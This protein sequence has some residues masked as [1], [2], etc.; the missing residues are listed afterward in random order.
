MDC[1]S[2]KNV[3][4]IGYYLNSFGIGGTEKTAQLFAN[5]IDKSKFTIHLI[6]KNTDLSRVPLL[7]QHVRLSIVQN[8]DEA[9][10]ILADQKFDIIHVFRSGFPEFPNPEI[11]PTSKFVE[12]NVFGFIDPNP[13]VTKTIYMSEW[14]QNYSLRKYNSYYK[15][16]TNRFTF[17]N[18]PTLSPATAD[19]I[20]LSNVDR[21]TI[22]LGRNGR[23]DPGTYSDVSVKAARNLIS[24]G[25][26]I[27]FLAMSPP[28]NMLND[29]SDFD[30]PHTVLPTSIDEIELSKFYNTIDIYCESRA[31]GHTC[32]NVIQEAMMHRKPVITHIATARENF[33]V[34]QAQ[35][36]L[37]D[38]RT[39]GFVTQ[40][41]PY[42]FSQA[43]KFLSDNMSKRI[44]MGE[45]GYTKVMNI[46]HVDVSVAKLQDIY[47]SL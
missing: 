6:V 19:K 45:A 43:L 11:S 42:E 22:I 2:K 18:N 40:N 20:L 17:I 44:S 35:T 4:N 14:L 24:L 47:E 32:G 8:T 26:K 23:P 27:H 37:V 12:T 1:E 41:D 16:P 9:A 3:I 29:L 28:Q 10:A 25:Y 21:D 15:L 38:N 5:H 30:I 39:T 13:L 7:S 31:D 34:F 36:T 33:G 46:A